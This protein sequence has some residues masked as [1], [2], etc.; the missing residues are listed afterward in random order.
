MSTGKAFLGI[1]GGVAAGALIGIIFAP[2][3][4]AKTRRQIIRK[5]NEYSDYVKDNFHQLLR[6]ISDKFDEIKEEMSELSDL[7]KGR[8]AEQG[9]DSS[10]TK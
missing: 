5:K 2:Q 4:G 6:E 8:A 7:N 10:S 1:L 3:K 9:K